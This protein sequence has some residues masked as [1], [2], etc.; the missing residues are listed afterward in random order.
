MPSEAELKTAA[1]LAQEGYMSTV[2]YMRIMSKNISEISSDNIGKLASIVT[3]RVDIYNS[4][5]TELQ[6]AAILASV[7]SEALGQGC[8]V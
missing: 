2:E 6:A 5:L 8:I 7:Q 1:Q 4:S 3:Y